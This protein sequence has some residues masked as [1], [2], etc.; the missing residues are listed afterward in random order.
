MSISGNTPL[1]Q[2]NYHCAPSNAYDD[3]SRQGASGPVVER[4][5]SLLT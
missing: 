2:N 5:G 4:G 1:I 3:K